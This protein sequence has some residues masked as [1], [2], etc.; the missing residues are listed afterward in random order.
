[1]VS[2]IFE[3]YYR[4]I[5]KKRSYNAHLAKK[6]Q[7]LHGAI[8][9]IFPSMFFPNL[10]LDCFNPLLAQQIHKQ[11]GDDLIENAGQYR[12][13][14]VMPAQTDFIYLYL[15]LI[16]G[17]MNEPFHQCREKFGKEDLQLEE[18]IKYGACFF[19]QFLYIHPFINGNGRVA[20]V[21]LSYLLS[22]FTV[23]PLSLYTGKKTQDIC[24][25]CLS[26]ADNDKQFNALATFILKNIHLT[27]YKICALMDID[28]NDK[29]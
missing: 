17:K 29:S 27:S 7:N 20:R 26:E 4:I 5:F 14:L 15:I 24:L 25:Q 10:P 2:N 9:D 1:V 13:K 19:H 28:F 11:I 23:V 8:N 6:V 21:L 3:L 18:A 12:T 16:E 22:K